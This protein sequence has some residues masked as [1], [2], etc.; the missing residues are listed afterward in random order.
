[1]TT[2][3][4]RCYGGKGIIA[5]IDTDTFEY[6]LKSVEFYNHGGFIISGICN[7]LNVGE[8]QPLFVGLY[9]FQNRMYLCVEQ[10]CYDLFDESYSLI[11]KQG[12]F[13]HSTTL[14]YKNDLLT[15]IKYKKLSEVDDIF[16]YIETV[17]SNVPRVITMELIQK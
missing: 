11:R 13:K 8:K 5:G 3:Y 7:L 15:E 10:D 16:S 1:M 9:V 14:N 12:L 4:L 2:L 17:L 6:E